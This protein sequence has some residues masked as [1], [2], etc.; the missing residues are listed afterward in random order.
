MPKVPFHRHTGYEDRLQELEK[1]C[2][3]FEHRL[4]T[5]QPPRLTV[6]SADSEVCVG[7]THE[8]WHRIVCKYDGAR[9]LGGPRPH[10]FSSWEYN[11]RGF[12][13]VSFLDHEW[14]GWHGQYAAGE[15]RYDQIPRD[16]LKL[17]LDTINAH[18]KTLSSWLPCAIFNDVT[19]D[20]Y[21]P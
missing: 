8:K 14:K 4:R 12:T 18:I 5:P 15:L 7:M 3:G 16:I 19:G 21:R 11:E 13:L 20:L 6:Y 17:H 2:R 1:L 10:W 9:C